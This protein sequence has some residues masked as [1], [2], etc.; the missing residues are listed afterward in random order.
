MVEART[1]YDIQVSNPA[2]ELSPPPF[3][4]SE[5]RIPKEKKEAPMHSKGFLSKCLRFKYTREKM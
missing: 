1:W 4:D 2:T 3:P 5:W